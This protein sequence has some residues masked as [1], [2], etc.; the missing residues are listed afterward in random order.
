[1]LHDHEKEMPKFQSKD[2]VKSVDVNLDKIQ[3][4]P[5]QKDAMSETIR[6]NIGSNINL[7]A[8]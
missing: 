6:V 2:T 3:P 5:N 7:E 1:M 8:N 4:V